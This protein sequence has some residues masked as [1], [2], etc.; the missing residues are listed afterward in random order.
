MRSCEEFKCPS[1][2]KIWGFK[3]WN[4]Q[5]DSFLEAGPSCQKKALLGVMKDDLLKSIN[6]KSMHLSWLSLKGRGVGGQDSSLGDEAT[7][8]KQQVHIF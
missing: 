5:E 6:I 4:I 3:L 7:R 8:M 1:V 2:N